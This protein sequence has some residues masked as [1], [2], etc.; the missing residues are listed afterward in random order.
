MISKQ[1]TIT[2]NPP[3]EEL[4]SMCETFQREYNVCRKQCDGPIRRF[5]LLKQNGDKGRFYNHFATLHKMLQQFPDISYLNF[6]KAQFYYRGLI[7][8]FEVFDNKGMQYYV[9]YMDRN[10]SELGIKELELTLQNDKEYMD[11]MCKEWNVDKNIE[12][13][14]TYRDE[15]A[16]ITKAA[17]LLLTT[18][19]P[20]K[21]FLSNSEEYKIALFNMP[22]DIKQDMPLLNDNDMRAQ[23]SH[24]INHKELLT[25]FKT[26]FTASESI[27]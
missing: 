5:I 12:N 26:L 1:L 13:Y 25:T 19:M 15:G 14:F 4:E 24:Y 11:D 16:H 20:S 17:M 2:E 27:I 22:K 8:P 21:L 6:I 10:P 23:R 9:N 18:A 7:Q 3:V